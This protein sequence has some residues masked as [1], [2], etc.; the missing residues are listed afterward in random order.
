MSDYISVNGVRVLLAG[1]R[2]EL[3]YQFQNFGAAT[4]QVTVLT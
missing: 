3:L 2:Y 1:S 4:C